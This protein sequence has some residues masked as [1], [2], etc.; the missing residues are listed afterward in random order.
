MEF[1][2]WYESLSR[3]ERGAILQTKPRNMGWYE[4]FESAYNVEFRKPEP[5]EYWDEYGTERRIFERT[6]RQYVQSFL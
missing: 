4:Y 1:N 5:H 3:G 2:E 6:H